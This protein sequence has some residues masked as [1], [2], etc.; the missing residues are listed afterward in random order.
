[1][2]GL[3]AKQ[4]D[5]RGMRISLFPGYL[6]TPLDAPPTAEHVPS[7]HKVMAPIATVTTSVLLTAASPNS[8]EF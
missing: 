8:C 2:N 4:A 5:S 1:M 3:D 6:P 7:D